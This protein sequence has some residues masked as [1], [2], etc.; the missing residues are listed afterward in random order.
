MTPKISFLGINI[1][2]VTK[3][4]I[5]DI[6][7]DFS[8]GGRTKTVFYVNAHCVNIA[9]LDP[10]YKYILNKADLVYAGG[11]G[12]VW[13][14]GFLGTPLPERVNILDFFDIILKEFKDKKTT[15]Y[16]LGGTT[17]VVK[18]T[19]SILKN[20]GLKIIGA[21][22]GFFTQAE[23]KEIISEIN[24]LKPDILM[25]GIGVPKQEKWIYAH[26]NELNTNLCWGVG[27]AFDWLSG[28]RRR[29][30]KWMI[31]CGLEWLHRLC[32]EP[33]RMLKRYLIGNCLFVFRVTRHKF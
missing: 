5:I 10:E 15:I 23:E 22:S 11:Q 20:Q 13:A 28:Y 16:L 31:K 24:S 26:S 19:E 33:K 7:L 14:A 2:A 27:A 17:Q 18:R 3:K 29:A 12:V 9:Q 25:V 6:L 8:R 30:P 4:E 1:N 21:R 32:Q